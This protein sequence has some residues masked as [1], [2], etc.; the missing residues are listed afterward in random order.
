M[1]IVYNYSLLLK[2]NCY[3]GHSTSTFRVVSVPCDFILILLL[4]LSDM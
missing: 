4:K 3:E 1:Y 2:I